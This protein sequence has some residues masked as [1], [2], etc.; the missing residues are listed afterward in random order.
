MSPRPAYPASVA[1]DFASVA[2]P[3]PAR[4]VWELIRAAE[5][6]VVWEAPCD[7]VPARVA[8]DDEGASISL[9]D[10]AWALRIDKAFGASG[11]LAQ[12]GFGA[13]VSLRGPTARASFLALLGLRLG[14]EK[15]PATDLAAPE[16]PLLVHVLLSPAREGDVR[17]VFGVFELLRLERPAVGLAIELFAGEGDRAW[18]A[19]RGPRGKKS[20]AQVLAFAARMVPVG[21]PPRP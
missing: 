21:G 12:V 15:L 2:F 16:A 9:D 7:G 19:V 5:P 14:V 17:G 13:Y 6:W 1:H 11:S 4:A 3:E 20:R 8:W 10:G 18:I